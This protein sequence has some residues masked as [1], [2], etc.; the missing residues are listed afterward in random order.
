MPKPSPLPVIGFDEDSLEREDE[1]EGDLA[2]VVVMS[3]VRS[4]SDAGPAA[5]HLLSKL[6][7][8]LDEMAEATMAKDHA[9][10]E[11]AASD[12]HEVLSK[13]IE[14]GAE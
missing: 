13:L 9:G 11:D 4:L 12:A 1:G 2:E 8:S 7:G 6:I 3:L 14:E 5:V 10:L